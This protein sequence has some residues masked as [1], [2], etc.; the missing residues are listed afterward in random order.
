MLLT[1]YSIIPENNEI[2]ADKGSVFDALASVQKAMANG[3]RLELIELLAQGEYAVE[4]L[5]RVTGM[6]LATASSHLQILKRGGIV[7][8]R[9]DGTT[10]YYRLAGDD[11]AE[12]YLVAKR[13][14]L[15]HSPE[16]RDSLAL[17]M[18]EV[19]S[20]GAGAPLIDA[21]A[22]DTG[23]TVVDVRPKAEYESGH[24]PGAISIP[25]AELQGRYSEIPADGTVVV[26]CRGEFCRLAREAAAWLCKGGFDARAMDEGVIEWRATHDVDLSDAE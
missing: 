14:G 3:R 21:A 5:A 19:E 17:Y 9:R 7:R 24:F 6:A 10:I 12:L 4:N 20:A 16:L 25:L 18:A 1:C 26:Y 13:V 23:M 15:R 22:V 2:D 8:T 11:V